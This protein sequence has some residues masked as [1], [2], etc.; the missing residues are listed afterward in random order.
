[1]DKS[2]DEFGKMLIE[3]VRDYTLFAIEAIIIGELK[4][5]RNV[6]LSQKIAV[7]SPKELDTLKEVVYRTVDL[8]LHN[9]L[10]MFEQSENWVI[11]NKE[12]DVSDINEISDGLAGELYTEDG[13]INQYSEYKHYE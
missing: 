2:L 10:F 8:S 13:W 6:K 1:M 5:E 7:L 11:S 9:M 4:G 3:S 12:V